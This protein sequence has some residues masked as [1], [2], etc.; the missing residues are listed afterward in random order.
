M[1]TV[2]ERRREELK[3]GKI[4]LIPKPGSL[5]LISNYRPITLL[6]SVYEVQA[7]LIATRLKP[8]LVSIMRLSQTGFIPS[9][10]IIDNIFVVGCRK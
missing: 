10:S 1:W 5:Q 6:N 9:H 4:V 3:K 2:E 8:M 7:K